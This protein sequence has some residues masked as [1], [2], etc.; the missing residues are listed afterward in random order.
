MSNSVR[1]ILGGSIPVQV[2]FKDI[3]IYLVTHH[4]LIQLIILVWKWTGICFFHL[5]KQKFLR[6]WSRSSIK[7]QT[8]W[9]RLLNAGF[10]CFSCNSESQIWMLVS[11]YLFLWNSKKHWPSIR[12]FIKSLWNISNEDD[13]WTLDHSIEHVWKYS[14]LLPFSLD[15]FKSHFSTLLKANY[16]R[17][18]N[19]S[20]IMNLS[21][22]Q[23]L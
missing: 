6:R 5:F 20:K 12:F 18:G 4:L 22:A 3:P 16:C 23:S 7:S 14:C 2:N 8:R 17:N 13:D 15:A 1:L 10:P 9:S 11:D 19:A 21:L